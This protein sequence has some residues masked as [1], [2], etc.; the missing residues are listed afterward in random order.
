MKKLYLMQLTSLSF[1]HYGYSSR[2]Y[3]DESNF[4]S[5]VCGTCAKKKERKSAPIIYNYNY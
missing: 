3:S 5:V 1:I 4:K 2:D